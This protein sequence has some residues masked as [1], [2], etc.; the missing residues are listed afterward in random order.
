MALTTNLVAAWDLSDTSDASGNGRTLTNTGVTFIAGKI[1][2][3]GV[4]NPRGATGDNMKVNSN[5]GITG[6]ACTISLWYKATSNPTGGAFGGDG[7]AWIG[8]GTGSFVGNC[9]M[10]ENVTNPRLNFWRNRSGVQFAPLPPLEILPTKDQSPNPPEPLPV[11]ATPAPT[12]L[13]LR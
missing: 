1:G 12:V 2:D 7:L 13:P 6:G 4:W 9:I 3:C 5:L 10:Y 8:S 11:D